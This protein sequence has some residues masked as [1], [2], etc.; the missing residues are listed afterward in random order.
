VVH[1]K[2]I[3]RKIKFLRAVAGYSLSDNIRN[4]DIRTKLKVENVK[5]KEERQMVCTYRRKQ[6]YKKMLRKYK[7]PIQDDWN[8][9]GNDSSVS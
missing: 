7:R 2:N 6:N 3:T 9:Q 1:Y 8:G 4:Y 5:V